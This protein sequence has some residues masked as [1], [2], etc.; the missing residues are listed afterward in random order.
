MSS[1]QREF[2]ST[3][4]K[5]GLLVLAA[6]TALAV[7]LVAMSG[8]RPT[9]RSAHRYVAAFTNVAGLDVGA[10]VRFGGVK[11]GRV[12]AVEPDPTDRT[13][14]RVQ[15]EVKGDT[16]VN[17]ESV[18][19]IEQIS[20]TA[21]KHLEVSTGTADA[22]LLH[23]GAPLRTRTSGGGLIEMPELDGVVTR[24]EK[25]LDGL[26]ALLGLEPPRGTSPG[27]VNM[28]V[29]FESLRTTLDEGA[30]AAR[31]V[32]GM[33]SDNR[34]EIRDVVR[35][36]SALEDSAGRLLGQLE[37]VVSD[38]RVPLKQSVANLEKLTRETTERMAELR[39]ALDAFGD[40]AAN[41]NDMFRHQR[42]T[43]EEILLNLRVITRQL[44]DLSRTM[45]D[46]PNA[47]VFGAKTA[48]EPKGDSP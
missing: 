39:A 44:A 3:E 45:A 30:G 26:N 28:R 11:V 22:P 6:T 37:G 24:L 1:S 18:A 41:G 19:S 27:A 8:W 4:I 43:I 12:A 34:G 14:I 33:I 25:L 9:D 13:R 48:E 46:K 2:T 40:L 31:Q 42:R 29:L 16:P 47:L 7:F 10:E 5:A 38:N 20:L 17:E 21:E 15:L 32:N 35:R 23:D 36:M